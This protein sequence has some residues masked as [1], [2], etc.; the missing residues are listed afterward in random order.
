MV[1]GGWGE[2]GCLLPLNVLDHK[3]ET[4]ADKQP[5]LELILSSTN[6]S[7][8][9]SRRQTSCKNGSVTPIPC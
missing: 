1:F 8:D 4:Q 3:K 6:K 7:T 2:G 9:P 5:L